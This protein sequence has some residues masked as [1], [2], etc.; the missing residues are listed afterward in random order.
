LTMRFDLY[1]IFLAKINS[2]IFILLGL[3]ESVLTSFSRLGSRFLMV[4]L[5]LFLGYEAQKAVGTR[6]VEH[7]PTDAFEKIFALILFLLAL[8]M[9][10]KR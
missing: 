7:V 2:F 9:F 4:L 6:L 8:Q 1:Y 10:L 3:M 5:L